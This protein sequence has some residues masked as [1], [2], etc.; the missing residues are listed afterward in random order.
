L[1]S[2]NHEELIEKGD[3]EKENYFELITSLIVFPLFFLISWTIPDTNIQKNR[4]Y[5]WLTII[6]SVVW[7]G[8]LAEA[9]LFCMYYN[10]I[11]MLF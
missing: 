6:I 8:A 1:I 11:L 9:L 3:I 4:K 2:I 5:Y 10:Y 7:M